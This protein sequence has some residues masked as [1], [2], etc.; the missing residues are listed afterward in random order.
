MKNFLK[1][2][3][4]WIIIAVVAIA[5]MTVRFTVEN[6]LIVQIVSY[7]LAFIG[8]GVLFCGFF[9]VIEKIEKIGLIENQF[10]AGICVL[11]IMFCL[12]LAFEK[13]FGIL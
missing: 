3:L 6:Y 8:V 7:P 4:F 13:L 9:L 10:Q 5:V 1:E 12:Y 11:F 2:N